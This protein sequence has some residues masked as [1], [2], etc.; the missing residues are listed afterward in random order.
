MHE[1]NNPGA[2]A[3]RAAAQLR[4]NLLRLQRLSL[5]NSGKAKTP[6]QLQCMR[7]LL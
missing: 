2:A 6:A 1:L 3:K 4:E 5:R 7:D